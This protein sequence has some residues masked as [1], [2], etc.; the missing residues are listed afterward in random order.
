MT[1]RWKKPGRGSI[2]RRPERVRFTGQFDDETFAEV[3]MRALAAGVSIAE[4]VR[5]LVEFGLEDERRDET[6]SAG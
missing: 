2:H 4:K 5:Q 1:R 3:R 6:V